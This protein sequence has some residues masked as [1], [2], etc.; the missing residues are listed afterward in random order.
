MKG[1]VMKFMNRPVMTSSAER[2]TKPDLNPDCVG[3][4]SPPYQVAVVS[5][6]RNSKAEQ[7][8]TLWH[9]G[10][11]SVSVTIIVVR[12]LVNLDLGGRM[13]TEIHK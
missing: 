1:K 2:S 5:M 9:L 7:E 13:N 4:Y 10:M 3:L 8:E 12:Y 6:L 11:M